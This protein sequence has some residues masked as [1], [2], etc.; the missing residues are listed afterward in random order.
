MNTGF[1]WKEE[2][3][4]KQN[5]HAVVVDV[6]STSYF[7]YLLSKD[8]SVV[9]AA[10]HSWESKFNM[11]IIVSDNNEG[12]VV[13]IAAWFGTTVMVFGVSTRLWSKYSVLRKWTIDDA[14]IVATMVSVL[15]EVDILV[16]LD[17]FVLI[18]LMKRSWAVQ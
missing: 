6:D 10:T 13:N 18:V 1:L 7:I 4:K 5:Y 16:M 17:I 8:F 2:K 3:K 15:V 14:F 9:L 12:P 11:K